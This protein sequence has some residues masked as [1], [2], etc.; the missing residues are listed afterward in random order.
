ME[1]FECVDGP[2]M[3]ERIRKQRGLNLDLSD[4][5]IYCLA[6]L[7]GQFGF[8][9]PPVSGRSGDLIC[10]TGLSGPRRAHWRGG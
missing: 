10:P 6:V 8:A 7:R 9:G 4:G 3:R 5:G 1:S 2:D